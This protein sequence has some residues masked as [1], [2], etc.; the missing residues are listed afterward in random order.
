M[1]KRYTKEKIINVI[2]EHET[3]AHMVDGY[4]VI[5]RSA[6]QYFGTP[7]RLPALGQAHPI[8]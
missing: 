8:K 3:V 4:Q 2:E 1:K 6:S 7:D 5:E